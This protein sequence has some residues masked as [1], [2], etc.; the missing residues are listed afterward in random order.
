MG[1]EVFLAGREASPVVEGVKADAARVVAS[2]VATRGEMR[3][4]FG[5]GGG[6]DP[7]SFINR[8]DRNGNGNIDPDEMEGPG[9]IHVGANGSRKPEH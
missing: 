1:R 7:S 5:G 6:F 2:E 3:M 4:E 9:T 8:M